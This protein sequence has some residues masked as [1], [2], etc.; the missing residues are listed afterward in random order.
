MKLEGSKIWIV[1]ASSGIGAAVSE[2]LSARGAELLLSA[3]RA[4]ELEAVRERLAHPERASV[5]RVDLER[6]DELESH[7]QEAGR[8]LGAIDLFLCSAGISQRSLV[9]ETRMAVERRLFEVNF[10]GPI[11]LIKALLPS[12]LARGSGRIAVVSSL[13]GKF[14]TPM[15]SGYSASK[16][17]LH[18]YLDSLRAEVADDGVGVTLICPGYVRT[19]ITLSSLTGDGSAYGRVD[20]VNQNGVSAQ[21]CADLIVDAV[22]RDRRE[23]LIGGAEKYA[24]Y[25]HRYFP[26]LFAHAVRRARIH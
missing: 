23:V 1:G 2:A 7:A 24:V 17:A 5:M 9:R 16:H 25:V 3:R 4:P 26:G 12:M 21:R 10:M 20:H 6:P 22:A 14:G 18:G 8:R 13:V 15:R 11:A 19:E